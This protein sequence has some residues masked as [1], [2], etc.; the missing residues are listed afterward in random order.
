MS[1]SQI[2]GGN[3]I[4]FLFSFLFGASKRSCK[5]FWGA[6]KKCENKNLSFILQIITL[7]WLEQEELGIAFC[8]LFVCMVDQA[9]IRPLSISPVRLFLGIICLILRGMAL[10]AMNHFGTYTGRGPWFNRGIYLRPFFIRWG[11]YP[12]LPFTLGF[13]SLETLK[14]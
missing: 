6:T 2:R 9:Q 8:F 4:N 13:I 7:E 1:Q 12:F 5:P 11:K 10:G 3:Y 14:H